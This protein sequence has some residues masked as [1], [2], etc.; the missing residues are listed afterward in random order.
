MSTKQE[1]KEIRMR[2]SYNG[3]MTTFYTD[4]TETKEPYKIRKPTS[5]EANMV[6]KFSFEDQFIKLLDKYGV[7]RLTLTQKE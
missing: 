2:L 3:I 7:K 5:D 4:G 1:D 6:I